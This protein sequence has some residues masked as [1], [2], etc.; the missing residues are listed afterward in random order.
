MTNKR[1]STGPKIDPW[2]TPYLNGQLFR[3]YFP[4]SNKLLFLRQVRFIPSDGRG[5]NP[6][7]RQLFLEEVHDQLHQKLCENL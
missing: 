6:I 1:K 7:D 4:Q 2:G 5:T 3:F